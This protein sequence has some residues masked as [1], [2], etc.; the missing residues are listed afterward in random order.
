MSDTNAMNNMSKVAQER[1]D[2]DDGV[3][4]RL[5][6][7][8]SQ[9]TSELIK[10]HAAAKKFLQASTIGGLL[11]LSNPGRPLL[12]AG[13]VAAQMATI[14]YMSKDEIAEKLKQIKELVP[15]N[16]GKI[17]EQNSGLIADLLKTTLGVE[18]TPNLDGHELNYDFGFIGYEQHLRRFP[19]DRLEFHQDELTAGMAPGLGAWGY[20]VN[21]RGALTA[22]EEMREKYYVAVQTLYLPEWSAAAVTLKEWYKYRKVIVVNVDNGKAAIASILDAGPAE[23]TGKQFGGSPE[24]MNYL[25]LSGGMRKGRVLL[26]FIKNDLPLGPIDYN[27]EREKPIEL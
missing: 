8:H 9:V 24:V 6:K 17:S 11:M 3:L 27:A 26:W 18:A 7:R 22:E 13:T 14:G 21:S 2:R 15:G 23:W 20:L 1:I 5:K 19:E 10:K 12:S 16:P 25:E 4:A